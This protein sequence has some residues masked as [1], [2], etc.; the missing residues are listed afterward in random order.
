MNLVLDE[1][2]EVHIKTKARKPIGKSSVNP[3]LF[4]VIMYYLIYYPL[5]CSLQLQIVVLTH[6]FHF[7]LMFRLK[8]I[9]FVCCHCF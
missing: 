6:L 5:L 8:S 2:E 7:M 1:A 9:V 4:L 3:W